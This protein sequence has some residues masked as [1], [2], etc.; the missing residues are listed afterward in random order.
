MNR[1][2]VYYYF[3]GFRFFISDVEYFDR[4]RGGAAAVRIE[5]VHS[6]PVSQLCALGNDSKYTLIMRERKT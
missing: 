6:E 2:F 1:I 5:D 4:R 3:V